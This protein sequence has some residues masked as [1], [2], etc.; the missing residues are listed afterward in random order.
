MGKNVH[1]IKNADSGWSVQLE[2]DGGR[3]FYYPTQ[4]EAMIE[5]RRLARAGKSEL[6]IHDHNGKIRSRFRY[7]GAPK[8][9]NAR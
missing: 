5:G 8:S 6:L 3:S 2:G 7:D 9:Y 4:V 1:V